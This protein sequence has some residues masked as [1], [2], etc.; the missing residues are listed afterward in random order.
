[1]DKNKKHAIILGAGPAGLALAY[2]LIEKSDIV[3]ILIEKLPCVG[4][5]S[6][7]VYF[8]GMGV[9][10]GGHRLYTQDEYVKSIWFRFLEK[11]NSPAIDDIRANRDIKYDKE[12]VNPNDVDNVMLLRN[13][14]SSIIYNS[15]FFQYPLKMSFETFKK[16]GFLTSIKA[17][18]SYFKSLIFKR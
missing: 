18:F 11:Q 14:F 13:R 12:G 2:E 17:G 4:G 15:N 8:D 10:I 9:D 1:M 3:P 6:R 7:T 5:L 16:L